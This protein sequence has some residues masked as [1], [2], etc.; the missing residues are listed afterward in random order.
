MYPAKRRFRA[1][2]LPALARTRETVSR[3]RCVSNF[4]NYVANP[5]VFDDN[6]FYENTFWPLKDM[7]TA[8]ALGRKNHEDAAHIATYGMAFAVAV[9]GR[10][11][12]VRTPRFCRSRPRGLPGAGVYCR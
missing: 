5:R 11:G 1:T 8:H 10:C 12:A 7:L 2:E 3:T 4:P 6:G 9:A